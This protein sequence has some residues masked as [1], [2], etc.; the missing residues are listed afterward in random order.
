[1][2]QINVADTFTQLQESII[3]GDA[4]TTDRL[5][6]LCLDSKV[7]PGSIVNDGMIPGMD[8]VG[9]LFRTNQYYVPEVLISAR[10]MKAGMALLRP[11]L[12]ASGVEPVGKVVIGTVRGD[13]HDIGKNLVAMMLEGAGF[14][15]TDTGIDTHPDEYVQQA[16]ANEANVIGMSAL[17]TTTMTNMRNTIEA[18]E[19]AGLRD[20]VKCIIGGAPVTQRYADEV[21]ADGYAPDA[22][23]AVSLTKRLLGLGV[24]AET[25]EEKGRRLYLEARDALQVAIRVEPRSAAHAAGLAEARAKADESAGAGYDAAQVQRLKGEIERESKR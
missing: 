14:G 13:L 25:P 2:T 1:M 7:A 20:K 6:R 17:L 23:S 5:V 9:E 21:H 8:V 10:A 16:V 19:A 18:V 12:A 15:V 22:A 4:K 24:A 3:K 11:L